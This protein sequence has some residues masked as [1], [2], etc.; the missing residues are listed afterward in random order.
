MKAVIWMI[1]A[2][3]TGGLGSGLWAADVAIG[4]PAPDFT[5]TD[6]NGKTVALADFKGKFVVLEWTNF[7]CPFVKKHYGTGNMQQLQKSYTGKG[8]IWL[9]I[10][11]SAPGK[12]GNYA[13]EKWNEM[14]KEKGAAATAFLLDPERKVAK[15]YAAK[16]T[17]HMFIINADGNLIY[18]GAIDDKATFV[19]E[20]VKTARN[21]VQLALDAAM[22]GKPVEVTTTQSYGCGVKY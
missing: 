15:L 16:T 8:V 9:T 1:M 11:S 6:T 4:K 14:L 17:P 22:A 5:L 2:V 20:D 12:Q 13:P 10:N 19:P 7:D 3:V 18:M 21:Y